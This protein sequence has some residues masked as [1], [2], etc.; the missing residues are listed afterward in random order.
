MGNDRIRTTP[1]GSLTAAERQRDASALVRVLGDDE[2]SSEFAGCFAFNEG[3]GEC[4][5]PPCFR[6]ATPIGHFDSCGDHVD[7]LIASLPP[8]WIEG[9]RERDPLTVESGDDLPF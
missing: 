1:G 8:E 2:A 3:R 4:G 7:G 5:E 9:W 6:V